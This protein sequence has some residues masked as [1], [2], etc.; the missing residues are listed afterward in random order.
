VQEAS[1]AKDLS[2][3]GQGKRDE[4]GFKARNVLCVLKVTLVASARVRIM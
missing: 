2:W 1:T 4:M 3:A